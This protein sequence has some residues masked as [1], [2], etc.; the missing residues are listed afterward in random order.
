MIRA[1][2]QSSK[3]PATSRA[4]VDADEMFWYALVSSCTRVSELVSFASG[5][6]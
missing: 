1:G 4:E 6:C 2:A 3:K 5:G